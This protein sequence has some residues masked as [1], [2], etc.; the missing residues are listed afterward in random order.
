[1]GSRQCKVLFYLM[2]G[3]FGLLIRN[4]PPLLED[5]HFP[6]A[7]LEHSKNKILTLFSVK[8]KLC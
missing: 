4:R 2:G 7:L 6:G 1:M 8:E 3:G 5:L